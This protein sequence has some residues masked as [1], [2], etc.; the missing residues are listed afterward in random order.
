MGAAAPADASNSP[1][2]SV[3]NRSLKKSNIRQKDYNRCNR[4]PRAKEV[5]SRYLTSNNTSTSSSSQRSTSPLLSYGL[6]DDESTVFHTS[7]AKRSQSAS[8]MDHRIANNGVASEISTRR[9]H[10]TTRRFSVSFQGESF[11]LQ[12]S[13]PSLDR[14][15]RSI[16]ETAQT[17]IS[18]R[19]TG[20]LDCSFNQAS[21]L[22][23]SS[24]TDSVSSGSNSTLQTPP[25]LKVD[26]PLISPRTV[27]STRMNT[28]P[29]RVSQPGNAPSIVNFAAEFLR[30]GKRGEIRVEEAHSLG[31]LHNRLLQW[32]FVNAKTSSSVSLQTVAVEKSLLNAWLATAHLRD[33]V[34]MKKVM[35]HLLRRNM[36]L[37]PLLKEQMVYL[38]EWSLMDPEHRIS[39]NELIEALK[40]SI[41]R[42]PLVNG[43]KASIR[44]LKEAICSAV[45]MI[46]LVGSSLRST[47]LKSEQATSLVMELLNVASQERALL[48]EYQSLLC[49]MASLHVKQ[50]S[51]RASLQQLNRR[52]S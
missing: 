27:L 15:L 42:L 50:C 30:K 37:G 40:A 3:H 48:Q 8:R 35:L 1:A 46:Q 14:R 34:V 19:V 41:L 10:C 31:V 9:N 51:L 32:Q 7:L 4:K 33:S 6:A 36:K 47:V 5:S 21:N 13:K 11:T 16:S 39:V 25:K 12:T 22:S 28:S 18:N 26:G 2:A 43:A 29:C 44:D 38:E 20:S 45:D 49:I 17:S 24:D 52:T 23:T